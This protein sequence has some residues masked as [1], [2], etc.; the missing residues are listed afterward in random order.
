KT[1]VWLGTFETKEDAARAYDEAAIIMCGPLAKTNFPYDPL[2]KPSFLSAALT[3]KLHGFFL[4]SLMQQGHSHSRSAIPPS[5]TCLRLDTDKS[6]LGIWQKK[7]GKHSE[8]KWVMTVK[9]GSVPHH[10]NQPPPPKKEILSE[11]DI[12]LEMIEE[13]LYHP[14]SLEF[15]PSFSSAFNQDKNAADV[16]VKSEFPTGI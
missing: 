4:A 6:N 3:T 9:V 5:L 15:S 1:R 2:S 11:E 14:T 13:L 10:I 12:A 8:S 16:S 7:G